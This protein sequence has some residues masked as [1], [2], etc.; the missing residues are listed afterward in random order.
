M[1]DKVFHRLERQEVERGSSK[2]NLV[3]GRI[4]LSQARGKIL[5]KVLRRSSKISLVGER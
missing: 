3:D 4:D 5:M 2:R 1:R